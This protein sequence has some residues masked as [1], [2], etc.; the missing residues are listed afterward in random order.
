MHTAHIIL[1]KAEDHNEAIGKVRSSIDNTEASFAD[2]SD[3]S[4]IGNEG[5]GDSRYSFADFVD[6]W[7]GADTHVVGLE[8]ETDLFYQILRTFENYRNAEF[9]SLKEELKDFDLTSLQVEMDGYF[10]DVYNLLKLAKLANGEYTYASKIFDLEHWCITT[11]YFNQEVAENAF[12]V[13]NWYAVL[14]DFHF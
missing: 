7:Q 10:P 11:K 9:N 12:E 14:V 5:I 1:V 2:W 6:G 3:W 4:V 13:N 8:E